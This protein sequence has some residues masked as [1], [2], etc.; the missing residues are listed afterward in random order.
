MM[1]IVELALDGWGVA[2]D[3]EN[4]NEAVMSCFNGGRMDCRV[5]QV[6]GAEQTVTPIVDLVRIKLRDLLHTNPQI[7]IKVVQ[8]HMQKQFQVGV[9]KT[10]AYRA[11]AKVEV[12]LRGDQEQ[13][14][15]LLW[16]Y[17]HALKKANPNTTVKMDV[18]RLTIHM[19]M[20][21]VGSV[22]ELLSA[23]TPLPKSTQLRVTSLDNKLPLGGEGKLTAQHLHMS[24]AW[25]W[26]GNA[27]LQGL[28][29][30]LVVNVAW[31]IADP[32]I[33]LD[34]CVSIKTRLEVVRDCKDIVENGCDIFIMKFIW[35][36]NNK[37]VSFYGDMV[38]DSGDAYV[39]GKAGW[40]SEDNR[41]MDV[42]LR[43]ANNFHWRLVVGDL[44]VES[45]YWWT[46]LVEL[47]KCSPMFVF[48]RHY[49][50]V[51]TQEVVSVAERGEKRG[52]KNDALIYKGM[53]QGEVKGGGVDFGVINSLL[54]EI[55]GEVMREME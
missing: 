44:V 34:T 20:L 52:G 51:R 49:E 16:D 33:K 25:W 43:R 14:Y 29:G 50:E 8:E 11:K 18:F 4:E 10:K 6:I 35:L 47:V 17:C 2:K 37:E 3:D 19:K 48:L 54:G 28:G 22:T 7:P 55:L 13:Q 21:E 15:A 1:S 45:D 31:S 23:I 26:D 42:D 5:V 53:G 30:P 46:K 39:V 36:M 9:S 41:G 27:D 38:D 24:Y 40:V 12:H 32:R